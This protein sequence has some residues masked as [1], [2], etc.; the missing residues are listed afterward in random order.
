[1][2]QL[3]YWVLQRLSKDNHLSFKEA[4]RRGCLA[5][6]AKV[7]IIRDFDAYA[8]MKTFSLV[9]LENFLYHQRKHLS[10]LTFLQILDL[11]QQV[12]MQ[13]AG[14]LSDCHL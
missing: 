13:R 9:R 3:D 12:I 4:T 8:S 7:A 11:F 6:R 2:L 14:A 10:S 1:M 5:L